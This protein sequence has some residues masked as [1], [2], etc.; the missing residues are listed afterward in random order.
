MKTVWSLAYVSTTKNLE[1]HK[2][3]IRQDCESI[4][5]AMLENVLRLLYH[6]VL[7]A[8]YEVMVDILAYA[9]IICLFL[10]TVDSYV[11]DILISFFNCSCS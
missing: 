10:V 4:T 2:T 11:L 3:K 1:Y 6:V 7:G 5:S 8:V 9:V